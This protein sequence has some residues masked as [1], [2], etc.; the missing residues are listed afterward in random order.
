MNNFELQFRKSNELDD[1]EEIKKLWKKSFNKIDDNMYITEHTTIVTIKTDKIVALAFLL[2]PTYDLLCSDYSNL[3]QQGITEND[4]YLYNLCVH[5]KHRKKGYGKYIL[6]KCHEYASRKIML[7]VENGNT[8]AI[9]LYNKF[10]YKVRIATPTG[11]VMEKD[12]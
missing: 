6:E 2:F 7:F 9:A 11:F 10:H 8:P 4:C 5:K 12:V 1:I 3:T